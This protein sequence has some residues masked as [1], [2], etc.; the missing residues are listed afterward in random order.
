[1]APD[2]LHQIIK[3]TFKDHLVKWVGEYLVAEHGGT[4]AAVIMADIDRR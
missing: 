1:M 4:R 3:D 2:L